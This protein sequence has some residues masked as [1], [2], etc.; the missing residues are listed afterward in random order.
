MT[1]T[2]DQPVR[3]R[4]A[5]AVHRISPGICATGG[6]RA[7]VSEGSGGGEG[8]GR[9]ERSQLSRSLVSAAAHFVDPEASTRELKQ[10]LLS[11][12]LFCLAVRLAPTVLAALGR[13]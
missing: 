3:H 8:S 9:R 7:G 13:A 12:G 4:I 10:H 1:R 11:L 5:R 2:F 6:G